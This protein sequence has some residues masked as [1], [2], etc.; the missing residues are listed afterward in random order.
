MGSHRR[1]EGRDENSYPDNGR[2]RGAVF[3]VR[4]RTSAT[5]SAG[6]SKGA[7]GRGSDSDVARNG[8]ADIRVPSRDR[9]KVGLGTDSARGGVDRRIWE[10]DRASLRGTGMEAH[11]WKRSDG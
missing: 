1:G 10:A 3:D 2:N 5:G 4:V 11:R 6:E 9:A 7:R 8:R